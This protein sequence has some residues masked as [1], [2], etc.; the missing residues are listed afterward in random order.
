MEPP[1]Q[2]TP[3]KLADYFEVMT[4]AV[5]ESGMSWSIIEAK[6]PGFQAAFHGFDP[7]RVANLSPD[8]V[9]ALTADTRIIR[10]RRKI[11]STVHNAQVMLALE[12]EFG[13]FKQYLASLASFAIATKDMRKRFKHVGDFGVYYFLYVVQEPVPDYHEF[14]T[15]LLETGT[16]AK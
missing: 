15:K 16:R 9:D 4:K 13:S 6:W 10:N 14:R 1:K 2:I 5:F 12:A 11:D 3:A 7:V 8:E